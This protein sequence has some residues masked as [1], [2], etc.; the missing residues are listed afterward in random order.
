MYTFVVL[1]ILA[2]L[3]VL[4]YVLFLRHKGDQLQAIERGRC[5]ECGSDEIELVRSSGGGCSGTKSLHYRCAACGYEEEFNVG[6]DGC[7]SGRCGL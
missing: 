5:P 3:G 6:G 4:A 2:L 1:V 7:A